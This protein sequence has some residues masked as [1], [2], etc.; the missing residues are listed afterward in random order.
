M[1]WQVLDGVMDHWTLQQWKHVL[2][3]DESRFSDRRV[4]VWRMPAECYLPDCSCKVW[5]R[6][7]VFFRGYFQWRDAK[8][9]WTMVLP[10]FWE[11]FGGRSFLIQ[12]DCAPVHYPRSIKTW[13]DEFGVEERDWPAQNLDLNPFEHL[14]N[15]LE[16]RL[17]AKPSHPKS[18]PALTKALRD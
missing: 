10:P 5:W 7:G 13:L 8:T 12:H 16:W 9:F 18:V 15:E 3:S 4:W 2:W 1:Q 17:R 14:W 6:M 11:Q